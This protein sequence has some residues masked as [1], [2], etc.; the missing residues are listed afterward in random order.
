MMIQDEF[1][2]KNLLP[3]LTS[4]TLM[5]IKEV[6]FA[7][8]V[9]SL[10]FSGELAPYVS[11]GIGIALVTQIIMLIGIALGSSV[12]GVLGSASRW[13]AQCQVCSADCKIAP[14]SSLR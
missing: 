5:G 2:S 11:Y 10:L 4:G 7:L 9:G 3:S 1:R 14:R 13:A 6:I 12:P 8:S